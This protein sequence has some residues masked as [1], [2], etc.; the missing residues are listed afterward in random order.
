MP[1][2][3]HLNISVTGTSV[4]FTDD[5]TRKPLPCKGCKKPTTGRANGK[6]ACMDCFFRGVLSLFRTA[7]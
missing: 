1:K 5:T 4:T 3:E 7:A 2:V 6:A